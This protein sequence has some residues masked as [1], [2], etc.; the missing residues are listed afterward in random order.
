M[1]TWTF[2]TDWVLLIM[3]ENQHCKVSQD[4]ESEEKREWERETESKSS[5]I[6]KIHFPLNFLS[7]CIATVVSVSCW[8]AC[9]LVGRISQRKWEFSSFGILANFQDLFNFGLCNP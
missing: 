7:F 1:Y 2:S 3:H 6:M 9:D 4:W 8:W 5:I